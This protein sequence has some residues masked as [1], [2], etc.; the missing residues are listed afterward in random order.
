MIKHDPHVTRIELYSHCVVIR[1]PTP[2]IT[3]ILYRLAADYTEHTMEFD[4]IRKKKVWRPSKTYGIYARSGR[5]FRFHRNQWIELERELKRQHI[6]ES[7]YE[8]FEMESFEGETVDLKLRPNW[9]LREDQELAKNFILEAPSRG[10]N[11]SLLMIPTG[12]GKTVTSMAVVAKRQKR[13]AVIILAGYVDKWIGDVTEILELEKKQIAVLQGTE[14]LQR[15]THYP[16]SE[17][18]TPP[19]F[20]I[21]ISTLQRWYKLYE[22]NHNHPGLEGFACKPYEFFQHL[23]IGTVVFDEAHQHPHAVFKCFAYMHVPMAISLSATMLTKNPTLKKVQSVMYPMHTRFDQIKMKRYIIS[24][25]CAY[26]ILDFDRSRLQTTEWGSNTYSHTAFEKSIIRNR[27]VLQQYLKMILNLVKETYEAEYMEKDKLIIFVAT[28]AMADFV[29]SAIKKAWP[30]RDTRTYLQEDS[31]ENVVEADI[32][33]STVIS[34]GTALDIKNLRRAILTIAI[35]S[36]NASAQV[37]GRLRELKD[38]DVHF[39]WFSCSTIPKH[40]E[41]AANKIEL[42]EERTAEQKKRFIGTIQP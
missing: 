42:Y 18:P 3:K 38:R 8:V 12:G 34:A 10:E 24:W 23:G 33:V 25:K 4:P 37:L 1:N 14:S 11:S 2:S 26:Q 40:E 41:Y 35:D 27:S 19:A 36:P 31:Y 28:K 9:T 22:E 13:F 15:S 32:I 30:H 29:C 39:Y 5:E 6:Y 16:G 21:S 20:I 7:S 17:V